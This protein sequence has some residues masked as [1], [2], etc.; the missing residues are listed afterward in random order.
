MNFNL[1]F[2]NSMIFSIRKI[3]KT[4]IHIS[5]LDKIFIHFGFMLCESVMW[6]TF[7]NTRYIQRIISW[8]L[9][10]L[11]VEKNFK[12][13]VFLYVWYSCMKLF[14]IL[15]RQILWTRHLAEFSR[16]VTQRQSFQLFEAGRLFLS[17]KQSNTKQA[18]Q[19]FAAFQLRR[20]EVDDVIRVQSG[21]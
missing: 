18:N 4:I 17:T 7:E 8:N 19:S 13:M 10:L 21:K 12:I 20:Q 14:A 16:H 3:K 11:F 5:I 9:C 6:C 2:F 1:Q 15:P